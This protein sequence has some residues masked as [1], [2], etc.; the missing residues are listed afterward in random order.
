MVSFREK[1][2]DMH[3]NLIYDLTFPDLQARKI[4]LEE[5]IMNKPD[6]KE[7]AEI[8]VG[9]QLGKDE[10]EVKRVV[11]PG[12]TTA[13]LRKNNQLIESQTSKVTSEIQNILKIDVLTYR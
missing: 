3:K 5:T 6:K 13:E 12:K 2:L 7:R 9:F 11:T 1:R 10:Y 8:D 4:K